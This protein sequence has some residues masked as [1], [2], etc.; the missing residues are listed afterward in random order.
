MYYFLEI[1]CLVTLNTLN[2]LGSC[3]IVR[4]ISFAL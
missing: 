3:A 4:G 1:Y 2:D